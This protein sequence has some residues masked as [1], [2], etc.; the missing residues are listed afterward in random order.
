MRIP[1]NTPFMPD[2]IEV[3]ADVQLKDASRRQAAGL[4]VN[5]SWIDKRGNERGMKHFIPEAV[6]SGELS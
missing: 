4:R 1:T 5:L 3:R 6:L 2:T